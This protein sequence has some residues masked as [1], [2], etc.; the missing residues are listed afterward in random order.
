[1]KQEDTPKRS[2]AKTLTWRILATIG[3]IVIVLGFTKEVKLSITVG[4]LDTVV[5]TVLYYFHE[6][7]WNKIHWQQRGD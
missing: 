2:M 3:T 6:R 5:K 4:I 7:I 1:M